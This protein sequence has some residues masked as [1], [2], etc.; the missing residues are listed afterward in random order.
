MRI[1]GLTLLEMLVIMCMTGTVS[2]MGV[3]S[4]TKAHTQANAVSLNQ[5]KMAI[6]AI[7][8]Q[9]FALAMIE[10]TARRPNATMQI[11]NIDVSIQ[12]GVIKNKSGLTA[13]LEKT[14]IE[15]GTLNKIKNHSELSDSFKCV[16]Y[17]Q[18]PNKFGNEALIT[19]NADGC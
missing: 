15:L 7:N 16:L 9:V 18:A 8:T 13:I 11:A 17:Y 4:I 5:L 6:N 1:F 14:L 3:E 2:A 19:I 10:N 12:Y